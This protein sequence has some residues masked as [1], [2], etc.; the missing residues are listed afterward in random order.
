MSKHSAKS[1]P[2]PT[3]DQEHWAFLP[4][5]EVLSRQPIPR[6]IGGTQ[7]LLLALLLFALIWSALAQLDI[8]IVAPGKLVTSP[9]TFVVQPLETGVVRSI[10]VVVGETVRAGQTLA[11]LDST[12][13]AAD[14]SQ[15]E[16]KYSSLIWQGRRL[17]ALLAD[18]AT[19]E[20][21]PVDNDEKLQIMMFQ[22]QKDSFRAELAQRDQVV[23]RLKDQIVHGRAAADV[24][25]ARLQNL[26]EIVRIQEELKTSEGGSRYKLLSSR[27]AY[28]SAAIEVQMEA[29]QISDLDHQIAVQQAERE[30]WIQD[31]RQK[32]LT[33]LQAVQRELEETTQQREKAQRL[34]R[35]ITLTAPAPAIV[36]ELAPRPVGSIAKEAE[37]IV[38][39]VPIDTPLTAEV[40]IAGKDIGYVH[41]G[42]TGQ[43]KV[44]AFPY[45]QHGTL[46]A[47]LQTV[48]ADAFTKERQGEA[49][50]RARLSLDSSQLTAMKPGSRLLPGATVQAEIVVGRRSVLSYTLRPLLKSLDEGLH[51]P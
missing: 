26:E 17:R 23:L 46:P 37:P 2:R 6:W 25:R 5:A 4:D 45:Q 28:Q 49:V 1:N 41:A 30:I 18:A 20:P 38:T 51:E 3:A 47:T 13:A 11:T 35:L 40:E 29:N 32:L 16:S 36:L 12:F 14:L 22:Q 50:Y 42:Q 27:D 48:S 9:A 15:I 8:F 31:W 19:L 21:G 24:L 7:Y 39:L 44:D 43:I 10:D 34:A 33:E